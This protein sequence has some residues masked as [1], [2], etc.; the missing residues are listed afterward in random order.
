M[1][2]ETRAD[3]RRMRPSAPASAGACVGNRRGSAA[4]EFGLLLPLYLAAVIGVVEIGWQLT[5]ASALDRGT[6]RASR[7]GMTGQ[8]TAPG[9]PAA[10]GCRSQG[11]PWMITRSSADILRP[12]RLTVTLGAYSSASR[13]G[14]PPVAGAGT[15]GQVV[16]YTVTYRQPFLT[17]AWMN[18]IGGPAE[19]V[20]RSAIIVRNEAFADATC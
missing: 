13:M 6:L 5:V 8:A 7:F 20:H 9:A 17:G 4:V 2:C 15:G 10:V 14:D 12:E 16:T 3:P 18:L 19:I 11:I 1:A